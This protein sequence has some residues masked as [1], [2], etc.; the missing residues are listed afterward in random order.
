[1]GI[2][3]ID[4]R[5]AFDDAVAV[6]VSRE[7]L[8][9]ALG[10]EPGA[11]QQGSSGAEHSSVIQSPDPVFVFSGFIVGNQNDVAVVAWGCGDGRPQ[12]GCCVGEGC[13]PPLGEKER[14]AGVVD[15]ISGRFGPVDQPIGVEIFR[16]QK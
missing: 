16:R 9:I 13:S 2:S 12:I 15:L 8:F 6:D 11:Q 10:T 5:F 1:M 4:Q 3:G 14:I 7:D